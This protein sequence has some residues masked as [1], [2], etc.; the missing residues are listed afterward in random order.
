MATLVTAFWI[1][2]K[3]VITRNLIT[4]TVKNPE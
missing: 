4:N 2:W 1:I 3:K